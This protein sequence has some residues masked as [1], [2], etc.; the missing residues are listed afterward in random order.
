MCQNA[1]S[2]TVQKNHAEGARSVN[3]ATKALNRLPGVLRRR[4]KA[5][6][7]NDAK[8]LPP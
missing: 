6:K 4:T 5:V 3:T 8:E 7:Q 2:N 1:R